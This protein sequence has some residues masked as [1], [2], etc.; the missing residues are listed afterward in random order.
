MVCGF[1]KSILPLGI[2]VWQLQDIRTPIDHDHVPYLVVSHVFSP[3]TSWLGDDRVCSSLVYT[4]AGEAAVSRSSSGGHGWAA[5]CE[6]GRIEV[7]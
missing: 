3:W 4:G 5:L 6:A 2:T 7:E 1:R